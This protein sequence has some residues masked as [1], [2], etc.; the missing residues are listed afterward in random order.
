MESNLIF[1]DLAA[2]AAPVSINKITS[3]MG[4]N[5]LITDNFSLV[6]ELLLFQRRE[7]VILTEIKEPIR[8]QSAVLLKLKVYRFEEGQ[9]CEGRKLSLY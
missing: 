7:V 6:E 4:Y 5:L 3:Y 2:L 1:N 8:Q 9:E